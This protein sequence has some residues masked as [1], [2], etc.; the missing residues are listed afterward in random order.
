LAELPVYGLVEDDGVDLATF[1]IVDA[2]CV[3]EDG[4]PELVIDWKSDVSP[5]TAASDHY[6]SQVRRY[7]EVTGI[8]EGLVVFVTTGDMLRVSAPVPTLSNTQI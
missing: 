8:P 4:T 2:L 3:G 5:S 1:G 7:L 6:R